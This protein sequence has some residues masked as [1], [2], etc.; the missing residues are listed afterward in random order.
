MLLLFAVHVWLALKQRGEPIIS[1]FLRHFN[2][3]HNNQKILKLA[4]P[5]I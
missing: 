4:C 3:S 5:E 2:N 1:V